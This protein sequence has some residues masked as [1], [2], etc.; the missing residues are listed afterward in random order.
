MDVDICDA[1]EAD[2]YAW[3]EWLE[4]G[5]D[6]V[7]ALTFEVCQPSDFETLSSAADRSYV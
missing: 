4:G 7:P 1:N 2:V 6:P 5:Y 3:Q